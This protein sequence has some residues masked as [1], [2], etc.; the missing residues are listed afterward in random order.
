MVPRAAPAQ[1]PPVETEEEPSTQPR[2]Q[3][4]P[5]MP[6]PHAAEGCSST[7]QTLLR[8]LGRIRRLK[9]NGVLIQAVGI[10]L[11]HVLGLYGLRLILGGF[12]GWRTGLLAFIMWPISG[13]GVTAG[14]HRLWTHQS[15]KTTR[16]METL[17]MLMFS[18]ADQGP[19]EGWALTHAMH[20]SASDTRWDPHNRTVGFWHAHFGWLFSGM[21][22]RLSPSEYHRV[23]RGLGPPVHFHDRHYLWWDP[24]W[25]LFV[26]A[27]V[28]SLWGEAW[29][30]LFVAGA[31]RW[32]CVQ[33]I[34]FFVN[35]VAHGEHDD[36][37]AYAFDGGA[38]G[39][40]PRVSWIV[41]LLALGEGWHDYHHL[42]PWDY[43]ASEL[44]AWDQWNPTKV[45]IDACHFAGLCSDRRRCSTRL[46]DL[47]RSQFLDKASPGSEDQFDG[48]GNDGGLKVR[49]FEVVGPPLLRYKRLVD[50]QMLKSKVMAGG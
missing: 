29:T 2:P 6:K 5:K 36:G 24:L 13:L 41:T 9:F 16:L 37:D 12:V 7:N 42:F 48:S 21:K 15:Y 35:S 44:N 10:P 8:F 50:D 47:R 28:A 31:L 4:L 49:R 23:T 25:S 38:T 27:C 17:L 11:R 34:T 40:G 1:Q 14:A 20:H 32:M 46:Q 45:F 19:I 18:T 43:A 39:I 22:F 33:H 26:P 30:G 3:V